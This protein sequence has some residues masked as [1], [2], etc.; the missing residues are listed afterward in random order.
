[1]GAFTNDILTV[2]VCRGT[3]IFPPQPLLR[4]ITEPPH[5]G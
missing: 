4:L 5:A 3:W 1:M 2:C